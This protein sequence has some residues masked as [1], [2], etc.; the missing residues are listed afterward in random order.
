MFMKKYPNL[1][2]LLITLAILT[3]AFVLQFLF[4]QKLIRDVKE[5]AFKDGFEVGT[6]YG[7]LLQ[8]IDSLNK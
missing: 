2:N 5:K 6:K 4:F 7:K 1:R 8:K 3:I